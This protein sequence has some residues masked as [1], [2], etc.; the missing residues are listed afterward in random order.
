MTKLSESKELKDNINKKLKFVIG[1]YLL[2]WLFSGSG[3]II[4]KLNE[5]VGIF[6]KIFYATIVLLVSIAIVRVRMEHKLTPLHLISFNVF[7][8]FGW[9]LLMCTILDMALLELFLISDVVLILINSMWLLISVL[10]P[11]CFT[12]P[13]QFTSCIKKKLKNIR[14]DLIKDKLKQSRIISAEVEY[15]KKNIQLINIYT[16]NGNPVD[17]E[18]YDYKKD[19]MD[20]LI[21]QLKSLSKKNSNIILAGDFNVIPSAED[22]YN[23]KSF[24][25]DALYRLEI[26]KKF[27]EMLNIGFSDVYRHFNED[28]EGYT[29]W[30]Y[31]RGAWQKNNGMRIDHF[32]VSNSIIDNVKD[33]NINKDPRGREKPSDHT[34]IEIKL[35]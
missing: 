1:Q 31:M 28:K 10:V 18:K 26:R 30:D 4:F 21:K 13:D 2:I 5:D 15:K 20:Q 34:P 11:L 14:T 3:S 16:P 9:V 35:A 32:L 17:T 25:D 27:R 7:L 23:V 8:H 22:V 6:N 19:W 29:F 12:F 24:E 33:I